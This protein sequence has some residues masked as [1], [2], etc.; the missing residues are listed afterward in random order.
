MS[1]ELQARAD[2]GKAAAAPARERQSRLWKSYRRSPMAWVGT[3][4]LVALVLTAVCAPFLAPHDPQVQSLPDRLKPP[5]WMAGGVP[6]YLLGTDRMGRDVLS[7]LIYGVRVSLLVGFASIFLSAL[8]GIP[9]GV[10]A[11]YYRGRVD[12]LIMRAVDAQLSL[13]TVLLALGIMA[14]WGRGLEKLIL[15]IGIVGWA[16]YARTARASTL[17]VRE[18]E[19]VEAARA[20]GTS[21]II[22]MVRHVVPNIITPLVILA[23]VELPRV[24]L[25][26]ATLS[27]LGVGVPLDTPSL[28]GMI[29]SGY[30]VLFSGRWWLSGFPGLMLMLIVF[31]VNLLGDWLRDALDPR[32]SG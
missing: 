24:V 6:Q 32:L 5:A 2:Q 12:A 30:Q 28:G 19:F 11:G 26:E 9:L 21:D 8:I 16:A 31:G 25:L 3:L 7:N 14:I 20:L 17:S 1:K 18:R 13:P 4:I 27:F 22:I 10:L 29:N 15:V 23:S